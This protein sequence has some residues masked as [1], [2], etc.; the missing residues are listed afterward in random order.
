M[1][2]PPLRGVRE[3]EVSAFYADEGVMGLEWRN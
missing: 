2:F 1:S 3:G